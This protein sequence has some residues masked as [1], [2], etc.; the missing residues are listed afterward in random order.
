MRKANGFLAV[1]FRKQFSVSMKD[2]IERIFYKKLSK[3]PA[4]SSVVCFGEED[5]ER[6]YRA[7]GKVVSPENE[8]SQW[9]S[10]SGIPKAVQRVDEGV[11]KLRKVTI[12]VE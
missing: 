5:G 1:V 3:R 11:T 9:L 12:M 8:E 7:W 6:N 10:S 2:G 4:A